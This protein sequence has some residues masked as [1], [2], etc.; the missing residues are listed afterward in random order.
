MV[1][2]GEEKIVGYK[3]LDNHMRLM[4]AFGQYL[5]QGMSEDDAWLA[6]Q[7]FLKSEKLLKEEY[8]EV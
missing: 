8:D 4:K 2:Y 7:L 1:D 5:D 3:V 6:A